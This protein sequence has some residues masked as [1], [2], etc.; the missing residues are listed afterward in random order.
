M[1]SQAWHIVIAKYNLPHVI[2]TET[3]SVIPPLWSE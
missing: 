3:E 2:A 1:L